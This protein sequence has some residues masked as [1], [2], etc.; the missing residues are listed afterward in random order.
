VSLACDLDAH[1]GAKGALVDTVVTVAYDGA[2]DVSRDNEDQRVG[3]LPECSFDGGG[4]EQPE[5]DI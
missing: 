3:C 2:V 4:V 1:E 5:S